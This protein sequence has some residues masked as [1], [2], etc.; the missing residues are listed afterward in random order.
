MRQYVKSGPIQAT[1]PYITKNK[2]NIILIWHENRK[3]CHLH[4]SF[5]LF[6]P[7]RNTNYFLFSAGLDASLVAFYTVSSSMFIIGWINLNSCPINIM[8]PI[9]LIVAGD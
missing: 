8:I 1:I 9:Y 6:K 4:V 7:T 3:N 5:F 2:P